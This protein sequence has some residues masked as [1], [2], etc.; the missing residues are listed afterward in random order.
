MVLLLFCPLACGQTGA[1]AEQPYF[2]AR[3]RDGIR[4]RER[5]ISGTPAAPGESPCGTLAEKA[6]DIITRLSRLLGPFPG[7]SLTL[8]PVQY[9]GWPPVANS[10]LGE[11]RANERLF[12]F[13]G[14]D[15]FAPD[16]IPVAIAQQWFLPGPA[17]V[18]PRDAWLKYTLAA[19]LGWR[20]LLETNPVAARVVVA[21][22]MR[23]SVPEGLLHPLSEGVHPS[24]NSSGRAGILHQQHGLLVLRTLETVI[25]RERVDLVLPELIHRAAGGPVTPAL[26][27]KVC[28]DVAGRKLDWFFDYFVQGR[29]IPTIELRGLPSESP[30][31]A[32]GEIIVKDFPPEGSVRVEMTV[33]TA[34]GIVEHSVA[35]RGAVTPFTVNVPA[36]ALGITLD[37]DLRILRWTEAAERSKAQSAL[38]AA[39]PD[40][41]T[42]KDL[43]TAI[44]LY[45]HALAADPEDAS[46]RAQS[47]HEHLGELEFVHDERDAALADLDAAVNGHSLG[48]FETY[49]CRAKAYVYR[50]FE[51]LRRGRKKDALEDARAGLA[52]P[53]FVLRQPMPRAVLNSPGDS[54]L[55]QALKMISDQAA[56]H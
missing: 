13:A 15:I 38:L 44:D 24:E 35:T 25:D 42:E 49:T 46:R 4:V 20:Y 52:L 27:Q 18:I 56:Q 43:P 16:V 51:Y 32:A 22:A 37:P 14:S 11:I 33:R 10:K 41:L 40:P 8:E 7:K 23:D 2:E 9:A 54:L 53:N 3:T 34:Q 50:G 31:V 45:R 29:Q 26:F 30:G 55:L 5:C 12:R 17:L 21:E 36:P 28:E 48:L 6:V 19:Y 39:L 1:N 47:L